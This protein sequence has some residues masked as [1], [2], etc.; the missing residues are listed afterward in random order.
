[1]QISSSRTYLF[2][3]SGL[4]LFSFFRLLYHPFH[5]PPGPIPS[6]PILLPYLGWYL[7]TTGQF[8]SID[9]GGS[10]LR[11]VP[12]PPGFLRSVPDPF[13][14]R[15]PA[16]PP[17]T[18][19]SSPQS[20]V[21]PPCAFRASTYDRKMASVF[22]LFLPY[23]RGHRNFPFHAVLLRCPEL[24]IFLLCSFPLGL[25]RTTGLSLLGEIKSLYRRTVSKAVELVFVN[26]SFP[27]LHTL[28]LV[29]GG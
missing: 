23:P 28:Y 20:F 26:F 14:P 2:S 4:W 8:L 27:S 15:S 18:P 12:S 21:F 17:L 5:P 29:D 16:S 9:A 10:G 11:N 25:V 6:L 22:R 3:F 7:W 13:L 19:S 24:K 1:M